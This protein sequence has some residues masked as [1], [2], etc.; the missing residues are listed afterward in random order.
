MNEFQSLPQMKMKA[1]TSR[2]M[3]ASPAMRPEAARMP[4][5]STRAFWASL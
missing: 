4:A 2:P 3:S 1:A 5:F